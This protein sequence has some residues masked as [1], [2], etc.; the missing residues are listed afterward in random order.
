LLHIYV[1]ADACPVK[2]EVYRVAKRY[3]LSVT[4]VTNSWMRIPDESWL[5]LEVVKNGLD[6][7]DDWIVEKVQP[8][9]IIITGDIPLAERCLKKNASVIG[10]TGKPFTKDNIGDTIATRDLLSDLRSSGEITS[11][12]APLTKHDKSLFLQQLDK[13]IQSIL[14]KQ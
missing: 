9:D 8:N 11:G 2:K 5:L 1:D 13:V 6:A 7:A 12:P 14:H 4:L 10:P 3:K